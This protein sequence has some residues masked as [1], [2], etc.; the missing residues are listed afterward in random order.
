MIASLRG[1]LA[2][3]G[4]DGIVIDCGG[5]GYAVS[6]SI[7][8]LARLGVA[9]S[10]ARVLVHT[11]LTQDALR[12]FGFVDDDER[13]AFSILIGTSGVGPR[14]ALAILSTLTPTDLASAVERGDKALL[15][16]IPGIGAKKAERLL[17]ELKGRIKGFGGGLGSSSTGHSLI[18]DVTSALENLGFAADVASEAA[19]EATKAHSDETE[20]ATLVR[21]ALQLTR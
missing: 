1:C 16:H 12:L 21:A 18:A 14:L 11:H 17:V 8:G 15:T 5:V 7:T 13:Q 6:M 2:S 9:G 10:E 4:A 3:K 19:R 20:L